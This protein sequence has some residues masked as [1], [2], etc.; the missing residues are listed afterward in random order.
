MI[1]FLSKMRRL[2]IKSALPDK[3]YYLK[4]YTSIRGRSSTFSDD[5]VRGDCADL[6]RS[7]A[8]IKTNKNKKKKYELQ[9]QRKQELQKLE[10][11]KRPVG[12]QIPAT[13]E[14]L[15]VIDEGSGAFI[16][17]LSRQEA[18]DFAKEKK[19]DLML[20]NEFVK[21]PLC[22]LGDYEVNLEI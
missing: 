17:V 16:G 15:K 13:Y 4:G 2:T 22:K 12:A 1:C 11:L 18:L 5:D 8:R 9:L 20:V 3:I 14:T 21:P 10:E 6:I 19:K 7:P